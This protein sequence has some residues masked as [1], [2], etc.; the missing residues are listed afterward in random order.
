M[1]SEQG[2]S[3]DEDG[4]RALMGEQRARAKADA[5]SKK[6]HHAD[7]SVYRAALDTHGPTDWQAY[8]TLSTESRVLG[9]LA[10]GASVPVLTA[11]TIGEVVLDR[12]P[13]Y[14]ESGGQ[15][16]DAG[17]VVWDA[18]GSGEVAPRCST[19]SVRCVASSSTRSA[20]SRVS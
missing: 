7:T 10:E 13:F 18:A 17:T 19:S 8:T 16:A 4:F 5:R 6:G 11:G 15:N 12:T 2:L 3:V 20:C 1:A 9:L 14:A